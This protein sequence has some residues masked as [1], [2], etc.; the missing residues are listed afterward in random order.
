M[1]SSVVKLLGNVSVRSKL[2][3]GFALV[4]AL[5]ILI[6]VT[7]WTGLTNLGDRGEKLTTIARLNEVARD[8]RIGA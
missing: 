2:A 5:T 4:L 1:F 3:L 6:A 8:V 7:G